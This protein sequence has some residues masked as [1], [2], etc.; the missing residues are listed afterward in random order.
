MLG[1][2]LPAAE[3]MKISGHTQWATFLRY[4]NTNAETAQRAAHLLNAQRARFEVETVT[5]TVH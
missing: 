2:G 4:V 1:A 5:E 3:V